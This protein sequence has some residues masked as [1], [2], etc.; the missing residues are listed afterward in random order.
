[1]NKWCYPI[2]LFFVIQCLVNIRGENIFFSGGQDLCMWNEK[3]ELLNK[4]GGSTEHCK[5]NVALTMRS[6]SN[7]QVPDIYKI[8]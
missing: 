4:V 6:L 7:K 3:G 2:I 5:E 8:H 1:M